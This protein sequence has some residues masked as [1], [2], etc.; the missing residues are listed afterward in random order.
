MSVFLVGLHVSGGM[1]ELNKK[2]ERKTN[3]V[4]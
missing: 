1:M 4:D 2:K 3:V